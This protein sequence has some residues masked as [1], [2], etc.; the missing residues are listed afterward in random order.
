MSTERD[1]IADLC[2]C[3]ALPVHGSNACSHERVPHTTRWRPSGHRVRIAARG[4]CLG[5]LLALPAGIHALP[6]PPERVE[7]PAAQVRVTTE[8]AE[9]TFF[10]RSTT[11]IPRALIKHTNGLR[12]WTAKHRPARKDG[13]V[14]AIERALKDCGSKLGDKQR[15][16]IA[17]AIEAEARR[18]GYDPLFVQALVEVE[19]TCKPTAKSPRGAVGLT[20]VRPATA[21]AVA[22]DAG[23]QW[24]GAHT[25]VDPELNLRLGLLYLTQ[26]YDKFGDIHLAMAAYNA[27]PARAENMSRDR[28]KRTRY[29]KKILERYDDLVA[30]S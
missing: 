13:A 10:E 26:L 3:E 23:M 6:T 12:R 5:S 29:V 4:L 25:L 1:I 7:A 28:A 2:A 14:R 20:Q 8:S 27:G 15:R 21:R 30:E 9:T 11:P 19:S 22:R 17:R 24:R 16:R 18:A